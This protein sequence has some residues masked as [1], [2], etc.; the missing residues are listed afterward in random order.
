MDAFDDLL[1]PERRPP[2]S[3]AEALEELQ[4]WADAGWIR[5]LDH[6]FARFVAELSPH[7]P[8]PVL[9]AAALLV[10]MEGRGTRAS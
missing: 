1:P 2:L 4:R 9:M 8:A 7:D 6:M 5:H 10:H 3:G